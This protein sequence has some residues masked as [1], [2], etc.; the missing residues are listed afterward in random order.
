MHK[1]TNTNTKLQCDSKWCHIWRYSFLDILWGFIKTLTHQ[2]QK[3]LPLSTIA[4]SPIAEFIDKNVLQG[5]IRRLTQ[6]LNPHWLPICCA[7]NNCITFLTYFVFFFFLSDLP[8]ILERVV[9][10]RLGIG[11]PRSQSWMA[12]GIPLKLASPKESS[13]E[14]LMKEN[15][16][17]CWS[18]IAKA[19]LARTKPPA[20]Q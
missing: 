16:L 15:A 19:Q 9:S 20:E 13:K 2:L 1:N 8:N 4:K 17:L 6:L 10:S 7:F 11:N 14:S 12:A 5:V 3:S 18:K